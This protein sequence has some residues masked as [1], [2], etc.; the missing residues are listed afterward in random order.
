MDLLNEHIKRMKELI[1][2]KHGVIKPLISEDDTTPNQTQITQQG[3]GVDNPD[4]LFDSNYIEDFAVNTT[5]EKEIRKKNQNFDQQISQLKQN[6]AYKP[7][8]EKI[9]GDSE[10]MK[11]FFYFLNQTTRIQFLNQTLEFLRSFTKKRKL[12]KELI[13]NNNYTGESELENWS[14][15]L[16]AGKPE[17]TK[18]EVKSDA[19]G[20]SI[21]I[22][23]PLEVAGRTVYKDNLNEPD[24]LLIQ[25]IDKWVYDIKKEF[26]ESKTIAPNA[27]AELIS[28][29]IASSCSRLRNTEDY[30]GK[31]WNQLSKDRAE[32]VYQIIVEK[33]NGV[34]ITVSQQVQ[35]ILRG[36][37]NGDGTSGPDP[38]KKFLF[39]GGKPT[40]GM[41][42]ST[43]GADK[44]TG[45]DEK[46]KIFNYGKLLQTQEESDQY[47]F[48]I[49]IGKVLIKA[50]ANQPKP[51]QPKYTFSQGYSLELK[52]EYKTKSDFK[53][54]KL[55]NM[56][57]AYNAKGGGG[58]LKFKTLPSSRGKLITCPA[59]S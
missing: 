13:K 1:N 54:G 43:T 26:D 33:L 6:P 15:T 50:N 37:Y 51:L 40:N 23:V 52:P 53:P 10:M 28:I 22:E 46:R 47:K 27:V 32:R 36:G 12:E 42:Y 45:P 18:V 17:S 44:L 19:T 56:K 14:A 11:I 34:G 3:K 7:L 25:A 30:E 24:T 41:S 8:I 9:K 5:K 35:K 58:S 49:V 2:A 21:E 4:I 48:C 39:Y 38:A 16:T 59:Y 57:G 20:D 29:D 55:K 31:T